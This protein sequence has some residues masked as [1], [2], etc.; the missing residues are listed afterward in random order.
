MRKVCSFFCVL[1][2]MAFVCLTVGC[3]KP[4]IELAVASQPNVNPDH[5]GRPSPV[6]VKMYE[7]RNDLV[8]K[9]ADF[10]ALFNTPIQVLGADLI[11]ADE[12]VLIPGEAR[13]LAY[14]PNPNT[15][16][17]GIIA[18]FRHLDRALW[19]V[20]K[21]VNPEKKNWVAME[22]NDVTIL[23]VP[24]QDAEDWDPEK[25]VRQFQQHLNEPQAQGKAPSASRPPGGSRVAQEAKEA[26]GAINQDGPEALSNSTPVLPA[27][28]PW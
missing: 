6:L 2:V 20:I 21:P 10:Q 24:D 13:R 18:G 28:R 3:S 15:R 4:R 23:V 9:Q 11:A 5:S 8:F 12:L 14:H 25:A 1:F 17:I 16:F 19:R 26:T 27:M 7:L 22:L